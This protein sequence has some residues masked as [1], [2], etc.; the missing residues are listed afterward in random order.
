MEKN[1]LDI[2]AIAD[3]LWREEKVSKKVFG[4][5]STVSYCLHIA[6]SLGAKTIGDLL[7]YLQNMNVRGKGG[8]VKVEIGI[9]LITSFVQQSPVFG[10]MESFFVNKEGDKISSDNKNLDDIIYACVVKVKRKGG[11]WSEYYLTAKDLMLSGGKRHESGS[12][13]MPTDSTPWKQYPKGMW[14]NRTRGMAFKAHFADCLKNFS[15]D[16]GSDKVFTN[17][18][19][20]QEKPLEDKAKEVIEKLHPAEDLKYVPDS[21]NLDVKLEPPKVFENKEEEK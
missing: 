20:S 13:L 8:N 17:L 6:E 18:P 10:D 12:W 9:H 11:V 19:E 5:V 14:M 7:L 3:A 21:G 4:T 16:A 2:K 1:K 15:T